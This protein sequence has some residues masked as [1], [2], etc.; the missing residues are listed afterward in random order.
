MHYAF[1]NNYLGIQAI[2]GTDFQA[3]ARQQVLNAGATLSNERVTEVVVTGDQIEVTT[4][5]GTN[6]ADFVVLGEGKQMPLA[7]ALG[8]QTRDGDDE[9]VSVDRNG[10]QK[11]KAST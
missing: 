11:L 1:L 6:S 2:S 7:D 3:S 9:I 10:K 5:A 4:E 8:I